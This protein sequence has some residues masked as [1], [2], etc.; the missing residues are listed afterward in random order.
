MVE[1][2][3]LVNLALA[4]RALFDVSQRSRVVQFASFSFDASTWEI[5]MALCS[6][7]ELFLVGPRQHQNT[8]EL[9]DFLSDNAITHATLPPAMLQGRDDLDRLASRN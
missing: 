1:H 9:L 5:I 7:A 3:G 2:R 6:G 4:Q 8:S